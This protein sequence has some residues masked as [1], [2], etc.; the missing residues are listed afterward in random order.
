LQHFYAYARQRIPALAY[1]FGGTVEFVIDKETG[2]MEAL[3]RKIPDKRATE[4][5]QKEMR[6]VFEDYFAQTGT[7]LSIL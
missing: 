7:E 1:L 3:L 2:K 5:E 4:D 6:R